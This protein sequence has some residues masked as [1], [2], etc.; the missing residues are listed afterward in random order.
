MK[1]MCHQF[2]AIMKEISPNARYLFIIY[3]PI[4]YSVSLTMYMFILLYMLQKMFVCLFDFSAQHS[5]KNLVTN[6][7]QRVGSVLG[8]CVMYTL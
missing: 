6:A 3:I 1:L 2:S 7:C 4:D 8:S 5:S